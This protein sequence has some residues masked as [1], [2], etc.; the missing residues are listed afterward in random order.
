M[1]VVRHKGANS[2]LLTPSLFCRPSW[3]GVR[4]GGGQRGNVGAGNRTIANYYRPPD[5]RLE[6]ISAMPD[7]RKSPVE[8]SR[9][10]TE[11]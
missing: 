8:V 4:L 11:N 6:P 2:I 5:S 10:I 3:N 7:A 1:K 9:A